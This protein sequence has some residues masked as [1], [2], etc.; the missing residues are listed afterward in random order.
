MNIFTVV[1]SV[2]SLNALIYLAILIVLLTALMRCVLPL[3][4]MAGRLR[5]ASRVIIT[6][7]KQNK[8]KK[9]WNAI[10]WKD[11]GRTSSRT[12]SCATRTGNPATCRSTSARRR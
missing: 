5:R 8:E 12:R 9:S 11:R 2:F 3:A 4:R 6:E 10:S 7:N 1:R